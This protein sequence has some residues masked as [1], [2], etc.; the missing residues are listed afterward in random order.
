MVM[1]WRLKLKLKQEILKLKQTDIYSLLLFVL[2]KLRD[3]PEYST[4]SELSFVL[5]KNNLLQLCEYFGGLTVKIPTISELESV[6]YS[7]T[8]YQYINIEGKTMDEA[9]RLIGKPVGFN[10]NDIKSDYFKIV[11]LMEEYSFSND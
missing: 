6:V 3:I 4:L 1:L 2:F 5:D 10:I 8:L 11:G 7:L 9:I